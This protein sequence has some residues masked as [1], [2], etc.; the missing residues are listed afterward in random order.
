MTSKF[1][2]VVKVGERVT[3][4]RLEWG[5]FFV[6]SNRHLYKKFAPITNTGDC[7]FNAIP[8]NGEYLDF[9]DGDV[10]V[11]RVDIEIIVK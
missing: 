10:E 4:G 11:T 2:V 8:M 9:F 7:L 3:F 6:D 5:D 1:D